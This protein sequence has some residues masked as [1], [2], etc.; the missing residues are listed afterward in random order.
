MAE[1]AVGTWVILGAGM[2]T[3]YAYFGYPALLWLLGA[4]RPRRPRPNPPDQWPFVS[5]TIPVYNEK[6]G[7]RGVLEG[8][9]LI[10]RDAG[11]GFDS[12]AAMKNRG[13]G[14]VSMLERVNVVKGTFLID[15]GPE[16]GTTISVR[17]PLSSGSAVVR[18]VG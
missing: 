17:V 9:H 16:R 15:S 7:L 3:G 14:L 1:A 5:V 6:A 18:A 2:V 8:I 11:L 10:V 4:V 13:L 12:E